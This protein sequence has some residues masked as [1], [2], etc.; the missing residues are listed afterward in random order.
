MDPQTVA[1]PHQLSAGNAAM[2]V[3]RAIA[4]DPEMLFMRAIGALDLSHETICK[5]S[6]F[7]CKSN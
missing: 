7:H 2:G 4:A 3:A 5:V 6:S 1:Y